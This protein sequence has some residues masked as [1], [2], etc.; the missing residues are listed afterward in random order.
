MREHSASVGR[1][2]P[3]QLSFRGSLDFS[4]ST[5]VQRAPLQG[6]AEDI[7]ADLEQY[8]QAGVSHGIF[9][10][11]GESYADKFRTMERFMKEVKPHV[12]A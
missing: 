9:E 1:Q 5:G 12:P 2:T 6:N 7:I 4:S 11:A 8:A 10:V 3:P